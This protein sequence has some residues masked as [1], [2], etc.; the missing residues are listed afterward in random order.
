[1]LNAHKLI[2]KVVVGLWGGGVRKLSRCPLQGQTM[3]VIRWYA[4]RHRCT[5]SH[6]Y[7]Q[8][9]IQID[10]HV[11]TETCTQTQ[12]HTNTEAHTDT[13]KHAD[14]HTRAHIQR[15]TK[16]GTDRQ[17]LSLSLS[18]SVLEST[19]ALEAQG[20]KSPF[21]SGGCPHQSQWVP[22]PSTLPSSWASA[23]QPSGG[24]GTASRGERT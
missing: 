1:M 4:H 7:T 20:E 22:G 19:Q 3:P 9:H 5:Q 17:R 14:R 24:S 11:H 23:Q 13:H 15:H 10:T 2:T 6:M 16:T 12:R 21:L 18:L 8:T